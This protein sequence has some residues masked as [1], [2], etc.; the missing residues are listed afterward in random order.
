[1]KDWWNVRNLI[2]FSLIYILTMIGVV[3]N[4]FINR[5]ISHLRKTFSWNLR[6]NSYVV[7]PPILI[8]RI[9]VDM[10]ICKASSIIF[11]AN[12]LCGYI[13]GLYWV[14]IWSTMDP[15]KKSKPRRPERMVNNTQNINSE[16]S[17]QYSQ[18]I[19]WRRR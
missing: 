15:Q 4:I 6:K 8:C 11:I 13:R 16:N 7:P 10:G 9:R 2:I 3:Q 12:F 1:M 14:R 5:D 19:P 17:S 18:R